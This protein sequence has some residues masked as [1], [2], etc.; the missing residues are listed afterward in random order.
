MVYFPTF[1]SGIVY[2]TSPDIGMDKTTSLIV[3]LP[4]VINGT[5][6]VITASWPMKISSEEI[7][8]VKLLLKTFI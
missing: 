7:S 5:L 8:K 1:K 2:D 6:I 3:K 4:L